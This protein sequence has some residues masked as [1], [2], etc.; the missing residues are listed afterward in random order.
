ML[1]ESNNLI[2]NK[3]ECIK[4]LRQIQYILNNNVYKDSIG[5]YTSIYGWLI[6]EELKIYTTLTIFWLRGGIIPTQNPILKMS[7]YLFTNNIVVKTYAPTVVDVY[8]YMFVNNT[9]E[10]FFSQNRLI[11]IISRVTYTIQYTRT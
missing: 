4:Y 8:M 7:L 9:T 1:T 5:L 10:G 2:I 11:S 3:H 6:F